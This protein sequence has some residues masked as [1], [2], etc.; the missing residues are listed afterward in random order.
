MGEIK[1]IKK[2]IWSSILYKLMIITGL[3]ISLILAATA[4]G[5]YSG[6]MVE[7]EISAAMQH[8][9]TI[10]A[11]FVEI[12]VGFGAQVHEWQNMLLRGSD[13][14]DRKQYWGQ[15]L[16]K[17]EYVQHEVDLL[18]SHVHS[19]EIEQQLREFKVEHQRILQLYRKGF[20]AFVS[21]GYEH[22][23]GDNVVKGI[24]KKAFEI[25]SIVSK[26]LAKN[27]EKSMADA[28]HHAIS[29]MKLTVVL[30][31]ISIVLGFL[32]LLIMVKKVIV[33]PAQK[34][35]EDLSLMAS[36]DFT[37][38]I[39][40]TSDDELGQVACSAATLRQ[41]IGNIVHQIN[42][43]VFKLSTS[44]EDMAHNTEQ[45]SQAMQQ[46]RMET[47]QVATAMNE[48]TA[49]V[50]EV[51]QNAQLAADSA[52]QANN[53]VNTGQSVV[54]ESIN[55][56]SKLVQQ[57]EKAADVIHALENDS[58]EIG[59]VL[60]V[61]RGIAEQTNL[62][63]L[64]AAIEAARAGEQGRGFAVVADEVRVLAQRTQT[65]TE[66]IQNMIEKLQSGAQ[67][68]VE[69]MTQSRSQADV[70]R[71]TAAKAGEVLTSI[72]SSVTNI[73]DMNTLIASAAEEQ[74]AVAEEINRSIVSISQGAEVASDGAQHMAETSE[75]LRN[76]AEELKHVISRLKV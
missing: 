67:Q 30:L 32:M 16:E 44:A 33:M 31:F 64:N 63:A 48:M 40:A 54:N 18:I 56:I 25:L 12:N 14:T 7:K 2:Y 23:A 60:D 53:E 35:A 69:A 26:L 66:E 49:T 8:E 55:A 39:I 5:I 58:V 57:V 15:F 71:D 47:D 29:G 28:E 19:V 1:V 46:Q 61:I 68:A 43:A 65:S 62:L 70:T 11:E 6:W 59:S 9:L 34:V 27:V 52:N 24:D 37:H 51:S 20:D 73:N 45:S 41:D 74:N 36:G 42:Q 21:S 72:T 75:N 10:E 4:Y 38:E 22:T 3:G 76:V 17:N 13:D 50:H